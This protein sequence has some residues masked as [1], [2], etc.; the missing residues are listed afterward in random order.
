MELTW[1][2]INDLTM[3]RQVLHRKKKPGMLMYHDL[4]DLSSS[5]IIAIYC[6]NPASFVHKVFIGLLSNLLL[7]TSEWDTGNAALEQRMQLPISWLFQKNTGNK[8][9]RYAPKGFRFFR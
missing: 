8:H 7:Y 3:A 6:H 5:A 4:N 9:L 2:N 1:H